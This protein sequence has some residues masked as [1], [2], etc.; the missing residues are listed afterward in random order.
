MAQA[1][2]QMAVAHPPTPRLLTLAAGRALAAEGDVT[3]CLNTFPDVAQFVV[4]H[5]D[6]AA[7][8]EYL[9]RVPN[10]LSG[11]LIP[12]RFRQEAA[13][14]S[15][16]FPSAACRQLLLKTVSE[17]CSSLPIVPDWRADLLFPDRH[18]LL[19]GHYASQFAVR[20]FQTHWQSFQ[21]EL[22]HLFLSLEPLDAQDL[23]HMQ[24]LLWFLHENG[25][26]SQTSV[27]LELALEYFYGDA[28]FIDSSLLRGPHEY[29]DVARWAVLF[30]EWITFYT[31][32]W[33]NRQLYTA[34]AAF[35]LYSNIKSQNA[36]PLKGMATRKL[37]ASLERALKHAKLN[38][39]ALFADSEQSQFR[40]STVCWL[41]LA[42]RNKALPSVI[43]AL[44]QYDATAYRS[45]NSLG[46][47]ANYVTAHAESYQRDV[48]DFDQAEA[49]FFLRLAE[50][51]SAYQMDRFADTLT[52]LLELL[53]NMCLYSSPRP[54]FPLHPR[55][56][57]PE[58]Y[59]LLAKTLAQL[60]ASDQTILVC[61]QQARRLVDRERPGDE[62]SGLS[63]KLDDQF[64]LA[65]LVVLNSKGLLQHA[66]T[67]FQ[68]VMEENGPMLIKQSS[69]LHA[70]CVEYLQN[71]VFAWLENQLAWLV[72]H[73]QFHKNCS[74]TYQE[75]L[76][77]K[78][79]NTED[80]ICRMLSV[81]A[82]VKH[83]IAFNQRFVRSGHVSQKAGSSPWG[84][85]GQAGQETTLE[86]LTYKVK[87]YEWMARFIGMRNNCMQNYSYHYELTS[88][89]DQYDSWVK[90]VSPQ[91]PHYLET[92]QLKSTLECVWDACTDPAMHHSN[93]AHHPTN[94][95]AKFEYLLDVVAARSGSRFS[96]SLGNASFKLYVWLSVGCAFSGN[97]RCD[98]YTKQLLKKS[99]LSLLKASRGSA[100]RLP[101]ISLL[102]NHLGW[103]HRLVVPPS[104]VFP[105]SDPD[106]NCQCKTEAAEK[107]LQSHEEN[108]SPQCRRVIEQGFK[109][110]DAFPLDH[111]LATRKTGP[112]GG[113]QQ[114]ADAHNVFLLNRLFKGPDGPLLVK[115]I[116]FST[117]GSLKA[118][119]GHTGCTKI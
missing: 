101:L 57:M 90:I 40:P 10:G 25:L 92:C 106:L 78:K 102:L 4:P 82:E 31:A 103:C 26:Q 95:L 68:H 69:T 51:E 77:E 9:S 80:L 115:A 119:K 76:G 113:R 73:N 110:L 56:V 15:P 7:L 38:S 94:R 33:P 81:V 19:S 62:N 98:D 65:I 44:G 12:A 8:A 1:L 83:L 29:G 11:C 48:K 53:S 89:M 64:A 75:L 74:H 14:C 20:D 118:W 46:K 72:G 3:T 28:N 39:M 45:P 60:H 30:Q 37:S 70:F 43:F 116:H 21:R 32:G 66:M 97:G 50:A 55:R 87:F 96:S 18:H 42:D 22:R 100:Y 99:G 71:T 86:C 67:F 59:L 114:P 108:H 91:H 2:N 52:L 109:S 36:L 84:I 49:L 16:F 54:R 41:D 61:F 13:S 34:L 6:N 112:T 27:Q 58:L 107:L 5:F 104:T 63:F 117:W 85:T 17:R 79:S 93:R 88:L 47:V 23:E 105:T 24:D 35:M 111:L